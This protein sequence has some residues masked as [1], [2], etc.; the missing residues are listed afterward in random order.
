MAER[1]QFVGGFAGRAIGD[2]G[3]AQMPVSG[4]EAPLDVGGGKRR[5]RL[6]KPGPD[7]ARLAVL[8]DVFVRNPGQADIVAGP[9]RPA[10]MSRTGLASLTSSGLPH[11]AILL[12]HF[13]GEAASAS[14]GS[15]EIRGC[16]PR[17]ADRSCRGC[18]RGPET[19]PAAAPRLHRN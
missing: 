10:A 15:R 7:L 2:A 13:N 6:E 17:A 14:R 4:A 12:A 16:A 5:E 8:R 9:L 11:H 3:F 18:G 19:A 1:P